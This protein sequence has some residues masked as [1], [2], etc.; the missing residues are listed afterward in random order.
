MTIY[1]DRIFDLLLAAGGLHASL[2]DTGTVVSE[3][4]RRAVIRLIPNAAAVIAAR[5]HG[6]LALGQVRDDSLDITVSDSTGVTAE[7][8]EVALVARIISWTDGSG[9]GADAD[10]ADTAIDG[11]AGDMASLSSGIRPHW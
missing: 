3:D 5:H 2:H 7:A 11:D 4:H 1:F 6:V 10:A 9:F 8:L